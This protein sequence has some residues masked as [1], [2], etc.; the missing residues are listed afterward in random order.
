MEPTGIHMVVGG[1]G[2]DNDGWM[3]TLDV[4]GF[5]RCHRS[6][7]SLS[8]MLLVFSTQYCVCVCVSDWLTVK[9][10]CVCMNGHQTWRPVLQARSLFVQHTQ[11]LHG[12]RWSV[13][14]V[15]SLRESLISRNDLLGMHL[16]THKPSMAVCAPVC[17]C[18]YSTT[19][20]R[21]RVACSE[22]GLFQEICDISPIYKA[23]HTCRAKYAFFIV[24]RCVKSINDSHSNPITSDYASTTFTI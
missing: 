20:H 15:V 12:F 2:D 13:D 18:Y 16:T 24:N 5:K 1:K 14:D 6:I 17:V 10:E 11:R 23:E 3:A 22:I 9:G 4:T 21:S 8:L 19:P 7:Q